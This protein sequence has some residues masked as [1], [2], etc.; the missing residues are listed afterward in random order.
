MS[1]V[2]VFQSGKLNSCWTVKSQCKTQSLHLCVHLSC[3]IPKHRTLPC[4]PLLIS[5]HIPISPKPDTNNQSQDPNITVQGNTWSIT[6][7]EQG[8]LNW[9]GRKDL[10]P[11]TN[12]RPGWVGLLLSKHLCGAAQIGLWLCL[13]IILGL[14]PLPNTWWTPSI[15]A[16]MEISK[17]CSVQRPP[18][19]EPLTRLF[20]MG[21]LNPSKAKWCSLKS[22]NCCSLFWAN[23]F[24]Y[25][26]LYFI[27]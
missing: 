25:L 21:F 7:S 19:R 18:V 27:N 17:V 6:Q 4:T 8:T 23:S 1:W 2:N 20:K 13:C 26:N 14:S 22:N 10:D 9:N 3:P 11:L 16:C 24:L 15:A 12:Q 5:L